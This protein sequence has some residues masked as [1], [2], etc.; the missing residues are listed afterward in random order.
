M[1]KETDFMALYRAWKDL[2]KCPQA[3]LKRCGNLDDLLEVP[4]FYRLLGGRGEKEWQ[5]KA[6]QRLIFCLPC[7]KDHTDQRV[8]L[9]AALARCRKGTRPIV[10]ESR[11]I[12]VVRSESPN[13]MIQLRRIIKQAE[14]TVNWP[15]MAKQLWYWDFSERSKRELLEDFFINQTDKS[16]EG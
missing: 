2:P 12:Q 7:I 16:K 11:M 4:A 13:D 3:E 8:T 5:K 10:S 6:Y 15:L 9:G 14:P 1:T